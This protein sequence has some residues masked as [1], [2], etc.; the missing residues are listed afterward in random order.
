M[1]NIVDK[2]HNATSR[3]AIGDSSKTV[4]PREP[5]KGATISFFRRP[6]ILHSAIY[7]TVTGLVFYGGY[8]VYRALKL[9]NCNT[10]YYARQSRWRHFEK[11]QLF[12]RELSQNMNAHFVAH[13][14]QE[15][16]PV[17]VRRPGAP[18]DPK[19]IF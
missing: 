10:E 4:Q 17:A 8:F 6:S 11:Q 2:E 5:R 14:S 13:L 12:Q 9:E 15:Y 7:G 1:S 3:S 18:L 19:Q 16:D